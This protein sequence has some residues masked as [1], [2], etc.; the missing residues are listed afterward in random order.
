METMMHTN[1][2]DVDLHNQLGF[3]DTDISRMKTRSAANE[4]MDIATSQPVMSPDLLT[5]Q[6]LAA[7]PDVQDVRSPGIGVHGHP[8]DLMFWE[9]SI[10][11]LAWP[12]KAIGDKADLLSSLGSSLAQQTWEPCAGMTPNAASMMM[13]AA[14]SRMQTD[15]TSPAPP[16]CLEWDRTMSGKADGKADGN[17]S[18]NKRASTGEIKREGSVGVAPL[19]S[20]SLSSPEAFGASTGVKKK[21]RP[22]LSDE[23][24]QRREQEK[25][26]RNKTR[27]FLRQQLKD[28]RQAPR[29]RTY[30]RK[31]RK[32]AR[33]Q[34]QSRLSQ[35]S[36]TRGTSTTSCV[37]VSGRSDVCPE[38]SATSQDEL[39][40]VN[41]EERPLGLTAHQSLPSSPQV[42][43]EGSLYLYSTRSRSL[44][45]GPVLD[46]PTRSGTAMAGADR[47]G[48]IRTHLCGASPYDAPAV[49][50]VF[51]TASDPFEPSRWLR[52]GNGSQV[53]LQVGVMP[54][55]LVPMEASDGQATADD[56]QN[57]LH[58]NRTRRTGDSAGA[59]LTQLERSRYPEPY[60]S[61]L[62]VALTAG[63]K[64]LS[65]SM[66]AQPEETNC[67][68]AYPLTGDLAERAS[69]EAPACQPPVPLSLYTTHILTSNASEGKFASQTPFS[70]NST[71][72]ISKPGA[73]KQDA[74]QA[75]Q[76]LGPALKQC[77][78]YSY[79]GVVYL[80]CQAS[81]QLSGVQRATYAGQAMDI[82]R[83]VEQLL[84][85][86]SSSKSNLIKVQVF[87]RDMERGY[88]DF[89]D[90]W[91][92]WVDHAALPVVIPIQSPHIN[93]NV[94]VWLDVT[95]AINA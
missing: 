85:Q 38:G 60:V 34:G 9:T 75:M 68:V 4:S 89:R 7:S 52:Y 87:L 20:R 56:L 30:A 3:L 71:A 95:A 23:E 94:L 49:E 11:N 24:I 83:Q 1:F 10:N 76:L 22:R 80:S 51:A 61:A 44:G 42:Q 43:H 90:I 55:G 93:P 48:L 36:E 18:P 67:G 70:L 62:K 32:P 25:E 50:S 14:L 19:T 8:D 46:H 26:I 64:T 15:E 54:Q 31:V 2:D 72:S 29:S 35:K 33:S 41:S 21:G 91:N 27:M 88:R 86:S 82:L 58:R 78:V 81:D 6:S 59:M 73:K 17:G 12:Q 63:S 13:M 57:A 47:S 84:A 40:A 37:G 77:N 65:L 39:P 45:N 66:S 79:G 5:N 16:V 69:A 74:E 28:L 53:P 92:D